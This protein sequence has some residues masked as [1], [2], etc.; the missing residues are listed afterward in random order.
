MGLEGEINCGEG[1]GDHDGCAAFGIAEDEE[2]G[3]RHGEA[4]FLG[5]AAVVDAG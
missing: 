5:F 2:L 3:W 1:L 4:D